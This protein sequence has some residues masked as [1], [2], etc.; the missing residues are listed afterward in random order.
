MVKPT[1][2]LDSTSAVAL[3][4]VLRDLAMQGKTII[5]SIHQPLSQIFQS[6]DQLILL[7][8]GKT[9]FMD[10]PCDVLPYFATMDMKI[11]EQLKDAYLQNKIIG[12]VNTISNQLQSQYSLTAR[13]YLLAEPSG[14]E[15]D[16][17][18]P[19]NV[20]LIPNKHENKWSIGFFLQMLILFSR[21]FLLTE[22]MDFG[23]NTI[24]DRSS[25]IFFLM[26][27]WPLQ[28]MIHGLLSFPFERAIIEKE[29]A[30]GSYRL[31]SYFV[32]KSLAEAPLK[33][34]LPTLFLIIAYWM[35][36][37]NSNFGI[38][39]AILVFQLLSILVAESLG[40]LLGAAFKNLQHAITVATVLLLGVWGKWLSFFKYS[41]DACLQLQLKG[42]RIYQC[43]DGSIIPSCRNNPNGTFI[44]NEATEFFDV[45]ISI[46]LNFLVLF[47]MFV[48]FRTLAHFALR[49]INNHTG[50]T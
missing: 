18:N 36:N 16:L 19:D 32:A 28:T 47:P 14:N 34:V 27:F 37:I 39:L 43:V 33:L 50:R 11:R 25:F 1:S 21:V 4:D 23:E 35:A 30:S 17:T 3:M 40:L 10:K 42:E 7:A 49:F 8:D 2:A 13:E 44:S 45:G 6:F 46:G 22:W 26:T 31:S 48:V 15:G 20:N 5:T 12:H 41:Y 29:R 38:F 9:I 24:P